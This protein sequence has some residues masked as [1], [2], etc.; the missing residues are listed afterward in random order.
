MPNDNDA[1]MMTM[2]TDDRTSQI[3]H[4]RHISVLVACY[5]ENSQHRP[6]QPCRFCF[7]CTSH[8]WRPNAEVAVAMESVRMSLLRHS[9]QS[10]MLLQLD[11]WIQMLKVRLS[12]WFYLSLWRRHMFHFIVVA[13]PFTIEARRWWL[14]GRKSCGSVVAYVEAMGGVSMKGLQLNRNGVL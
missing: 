3:W 7:R 4:Q 12:T 11:V 1:V 13:S 10:N 5:N 9:V 8:V 14:L 2:I 6:P